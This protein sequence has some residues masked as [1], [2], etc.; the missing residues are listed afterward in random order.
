VEIESDGDESKLDNCSKLD[1]KVTIGS[2]VKTIS[3]PTSLTSITGDLVIDGAS[4][5]TSFEAPGLKT[6]GGSFTLTGLTVL[7]TLSC[8]ELVSVGDIKWT[9]LPALQ[10]LSFTKQVSKAKTV[11]VTDTLLSSLDG[12]NLQ[13]AVQFNINNNRYLKTVN[14]QLSSVSDLL[15]IEANG[16]G[17]NASFPD[18]TWANN[19]T[20]RDAGDVFFPKLESVNSSAAFV[21]NTF[22]TVSFPEL[23]SVGESF[24]FISCSRLTNITANSLKDVGGTF[25]LANNTKL[26][27]VDGFS[28]LQKVGGAIDFSG[29]FT[30]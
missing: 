18:L 28:S 4:G 7:S 13:T 14:V 29:V 5:L 30:E 21:N 10:Q 17:V 19:I 3:L 6:I 22:Q 12:I 23:T 11:L 16:K 20:I 8:P 24:A 2:K 27:K 25:Q 15:I 1:G 26:A 9:T